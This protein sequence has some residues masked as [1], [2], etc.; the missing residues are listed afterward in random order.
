MR[1]DTSR[2]LLAVLVAWGVGIS[3]GKDEMPRSQ[4]G[5]NAACFAVKYFGIHCSLEDAY[6]QIAVTPEGNVNLEQLRQY[7][8]GFGLEVRGIRNPT[9]SQA[10][11]YLDRGACIVLQWTKFV[12]DI[13][14]EHI[15]SLV[16]VPAKGYMLFDFPY[17]MR[18]LSPE[19]VSAYVQDSHGILIVAPESFPA[20]RR[21][22][23]RVY[24]PVLCLGVL[25]LVAAQ[26]I[27]GVP[28]E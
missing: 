3:Y 1:K 25:V 15:F 10:R 22:L 8:G 12:K 17:N 7:M 13:S 24:L 5:I 19:Q 28:L 27:Y 2:L 11:D 6:D 18:Y 4:C 9:A 14:L 16:K 23:A 26:S 20:P 21:S